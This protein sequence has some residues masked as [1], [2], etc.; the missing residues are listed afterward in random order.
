MRA[1]AHELERYT[2][3]NPLRPKSKPNA[4]PRVGFVIEIGAR[5][6]RRLR[7]WR[8]SVSVSPVSEQW[9]RQHAIEAVK[10]EGDG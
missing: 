4:A 6:L 2:L 8:K 9:L 10:H 3:L 5:T 7:L 1:N